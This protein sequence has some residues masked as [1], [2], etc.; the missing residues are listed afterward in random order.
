MS[1]TPDGRLVPTPDLLVRW[2]AYSLLGMCFLNGVGFLYIG[3]RARR[4]A[5]WIPGIVYLVAGPAYLLFSSEGALQPE[6]K[7]WIWGAVAWLAVWAVSFAHLFVITAWLSWRAD[8]PPAQA[9]P[10]APGGAGHPAPPPGP[11]GLPA[12]LAPPPGQH[13][14]PGPAASA[15][16]VT[17]PPVPVDVNTAGSEQLGTLPGFDPDRVR[18]VLGERLARRGFGSVE[19]FAAAASLAPHEFVR[20]RELVVCV[21]GPPARPE[22]PTQ[23]RILDV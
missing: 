10:P 15:A 11:V 23:G 16:P 14:G 22:P 8:H 17:A 2:L 5:W 3:L 20:V 13:Y 19:E 1:T 6:A 9:Q 7:V 12:G 21:P 18:R 4:P